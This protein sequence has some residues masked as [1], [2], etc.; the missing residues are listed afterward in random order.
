MKIAVLGT[1]QVGET[2]ASKLVSLGHQVKMGSRTQNNEKAIAFASKF[3]ENASHGTFAEA[4]EF[5][6]IIVNAT[7]GV[8]SLEALHLAGVDN[9]NGKIL[10]DVSNPLDFS[11][12]QPATLLHV[13]TTSLGEEIQAQFPDVKVVKTLNTMWNGLMVNPKMIGN[14]DHNVFVSGNDTDAKNKVKEILISFD[15]LSN[16][17]IDLGDITTARGPEMYLPM[18]LRIWGATNNGAFN[19]K[20]VS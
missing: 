4:A 19:I 11:K 1:G 13:N 10:I 7:A 12:G 15:W 18:W 2:I 6:E 16:N 8:N 9:L 20:I 14:G 5:A 17:I 3:S